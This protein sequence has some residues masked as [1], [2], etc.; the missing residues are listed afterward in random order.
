MQMEVSLRTRAHAR[1]CNRSTMKP[2]RG[3]GEA[4][5]NNHPELNLEETVTSSASVRNRSEIGQHVFV[6]CVSQTCVDMRLCDSVAGFLCVY[7]E[8]YQLVA[9]L[10][11]CH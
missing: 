10:P 11:D 1:M 5:A 2:A 3:Q 8:L 6:T 9:P 7:S 4:V